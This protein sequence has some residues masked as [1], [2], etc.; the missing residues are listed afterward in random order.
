MADNTVINS[1]TGGDTIRD[2]DR[3]G[4]KTQV[5]GLDI[6]PGGAERLMTAGQQTA[7]NSVPVVIASDQT[8][9]RAGTATDASV[10]DSA[11]SVTILAANALRRGAMVYNDSTA[12]LYL[13]FSSSAASATS[14]GVKLFADDFY[15]LSAGMVYTGAIT[16]IWATAAGGAAR[17]TEL[18]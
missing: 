18:T 4:I 11:T 1:G 3:S 6:N 7:A 9:R 14:F 16:G 13:R 15:E 12:T 8:P 10:A 17:V 5:L 2:I